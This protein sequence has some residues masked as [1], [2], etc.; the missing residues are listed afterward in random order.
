MKSKMLSKKNKLSKILLSFLKFSLLFLVMLIIRS[1]DWAEKEWQGINFA[2]IV[3]QLNAPMKGT[4]PEVIKEYMNYCVTWSVLTAIVIFLLIS[5]FYAM[6][7]G[8]YIKFVIRFFSYKIS[9]N[10][11]RNCWRW[12][13][14]IGIFCTII[15]SLGII[16]YKANCLEFFEYIRNVFDKT[17]IY[18]EYY[19][20]PDEVNLSFP[21]Q[22]RNLILIYLES[23]ESTYSSFEEGGGKSADYMPELTELAK[24]YINFSETDKLGGGY[25]CPNT[26]WTMGALL[27]TSAGV[28]FS[29]NIDGNS[30]E[31]YT[32]FLPGLKTLGDILNDAGYKNYFACGSDAY[33]GGREL[34]YKNHGSYNIQDYNFAI[35]ENY[36]PSD[37]NVFWGMEDKK[38]FEMAR[39]ELNKI[40]ESGETF[41]Y[42]MLTVDTHHPAGYI[43]DLCENNFQEQYANVIACSSKQTYDFIE[44]ISEQEWY[45]NT[46]VILLG[47]HN[48]MAVNFWDDIGDYNRKTYNCFINIPADID[49]TNAKYREFCTLDYFPTILAAINVDI[50]GE[51]LGLGTNLFSGKCT[52]MEEIGKDNL[53]EELVK[54]SKFYV[55]KFE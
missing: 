48:S 8:I 33:F 23:M 11:K 41:N 38:L 35:A 47:D 20:D 5:F 18:D 37:Y 25:V 10:I 52:L 22:K 29:M 12:M 1:T 39:N 40:G 27:G 4:N 44:W 13:G 30:M 49:E 6:S 26:G 46:T 28:P 17:L 24:C 31:N 53:F 21:E 14:R 2:T 55:S 43:C 16:Y 9:L 54:Y 7:K 51:R 15:F 42:T 19:T 3:F 45:E 50:P 34:F 36:I 32:E